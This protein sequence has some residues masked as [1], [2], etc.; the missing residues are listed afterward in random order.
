M[1]SFIMTFH[2][3]MMLPYL[4]SLIFDHF[5]L[6]MPI[7]YLWSLPFIYA[8]FLKSCLDFSCLFLIIK[9]RAVVFKFHPKSL[10]G[11]HWTQHIYFR[12]C[13]LFVPNIYFLLFICCS[14]L[15]HVCKWIKR[16][17]RKTLARSSLAIWFF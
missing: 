13:R 7:L 15:R 6:F 4:R 10:S 12:H 5:N 14:Q 3:H 11:F 16:W 17:F 2:T 9:Q 1:V 8:F